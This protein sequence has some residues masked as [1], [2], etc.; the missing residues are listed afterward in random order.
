MSNRSKIILFYSIILG[1]KGGKNKKKGST[2]FSVFL[3]MK[4]RVRESDDPANLSRT[5]GRSLP[6]IELSNMNPPHR[7]KLNLLI[8][9]MVL[10]SDGSSEI[11]AHVRSNFYY[12][13]CVRHLIRSRAVTFFPSNVRQHV[14]DYHLM[15]VP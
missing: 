3:T 7:L 12:L 5:P 11:G 15:Q 6:L 2:N 10:M 8:W 1:R 14:L 13:I 4:R 9:T